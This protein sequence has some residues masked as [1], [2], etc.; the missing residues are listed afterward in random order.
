MS[1]IEPLMVTMEVASALTSIPMGT[2]REMTADGRILSTKVGKRRYVY[3]T[4]IKRLT[5]PARVQE[6]AG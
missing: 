2:L 6:A 3:T 5:T 1:T 4:E